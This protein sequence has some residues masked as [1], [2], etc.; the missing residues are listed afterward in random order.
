LG[1]SLRTNHPWGRGEAF[2]LLRAKAASLLPHSVCTWGPLVVGYSAYAFCGRFSEKKRCKEQ[3]KYQEKQVITNIV[4]VSYSNFWRC[5]LKICAAVQLFVRLL[6]AKYSESCN[7]A[8]V[9]IFLNN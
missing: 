6:F 1:T 3:R 4:V 7:A 9:I 8:A 5:D 2:L